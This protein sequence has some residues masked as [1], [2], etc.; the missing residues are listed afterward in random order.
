MAF[1]GRYK[2]PPSVPDTLN[3]FET[4]SSPLPTTFF[5]TNF[6]NRNVEFN[7]KLLSPPPVPHPLLT[8]T[9]CDPETSPQEEAHQDFG[10]VDPADQQPP[11]D[12]AP[13]EIELG[14]AEDPYPLWR[15]GVSGRFVRPFC[16]EG[17][18]PSTGWDQDTIAGGEDPSTGW[19]QGMIVEGKDPVPRW[20]QG[21]IIEGEDPYTR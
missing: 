6:E 16:V 21:M 4:L 10:A 9:Q 2:S 18:D 8:T 1:L 12:D 19:G 11:T 13:D 7:G 17:E 20:G 14:D 3:P 15:K 5:R